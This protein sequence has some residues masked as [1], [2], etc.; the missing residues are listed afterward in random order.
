MEDDENRHPFRDWEPPLPPA[1]ETATGEARRVGVE[2]EMI[3]PGVSDVSA[4]V[5]DQVGGRCEKKSPYEHIVHGDEAGEWRVELD[6]EYLKRK[7]REEAPDTDLAAFVDETAERLVRAGAETIVPVEVISPPLPMRRLADLQSLIVRLRDAGARGTGAGISYAFGLQ[8]NPELP[9]LD[10]RTI[11]SYLK[12]FFCLY[13]W[14]EKRSAPDFTRKLTRFTAPFPA[15]YVRKTI[16][17]EYWPPQDRLIDDYL[18]DNP[19][20]NRALDM[21]PLFLHL[22]EARVRAVVED[23]RVKPRPTL[24]Y[25]LP[26]CEIDEPGWGIHIPWGDWLKVERLATDRDRLERI[27]RAYARWLDK[28]MRHLFENWAREVESWL[29]EKAGR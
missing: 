16:D 4:I 13:E 21:L 7:G 26:N 6:W 18:A 23:P 14:L 1:R 9:S 28:P 20:R 3:G 8:L 5:A 24:H 2:L 15:A 25:R 11:A 29:G 12:A 22:D 10:A 17:P 27:C 19:T